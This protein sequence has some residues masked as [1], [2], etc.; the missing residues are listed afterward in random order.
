[1]GDRVDKITGYIYVADSGYDNDDPAINEAGK[2]IQV[3]P[4]TGSQ[5]LIASGN[6]CNTFLPNVACQNMTSAGSYLAHPYGIAIDYSLVPATIVVADMSSF[7]GKGAI[8]RIQPV[9]N[10][11]QTL[12]WGPAPR[13]QRR[14]CFRLSPVGCPMGVTVEPNGNILTTVF[15]YPVPTSP[16]FPTTRRD[17]LWMCTARYL[18]NRSGK[19][20]SDGP[21]HQCPAV[22]IQSHLRHW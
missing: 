4:A 11:T 9:P 7:S 10:G 13:Y 3:D 1:M 17:V 18:P 20:C 16:S 8:V 6:P 5:V 2:I 21:E 19:Q 12:L 14:K 15:T 22:A